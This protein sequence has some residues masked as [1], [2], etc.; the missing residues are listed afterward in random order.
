MKNLVVC[1]TSAFRILREFVSLSYDCSAYIKTPDYPTP[2]PDRGSE[3]ERGRALIQMVDTV[4]HSIGR[5]ND[6][7]EE[8]FFVTKIF[9]R[10]VCE[11]TLSAG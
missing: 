6:R 10:T 9:V 1:A 2:T 11:Y 3:A 4:S 8:Y 5:L 7:V